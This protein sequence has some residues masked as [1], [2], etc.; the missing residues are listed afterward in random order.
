MKL[1]DV[2]VE[3]SKQYNDVC[4]ACVKGK[5]SGKKE[6]LDLCELIEVI[7]PGGCRYILTLIDYYSHFWKEKGQTRQKIKEFVNL[8]KF[9]KEN[10]FFHQYLLSYCP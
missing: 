9:L 10:E 6:H 2:G 1:Y 5:L 7:T 8:N 3:P 4:A